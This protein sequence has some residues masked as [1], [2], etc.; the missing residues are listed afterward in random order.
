VP[1]GQHPASPRFLLSLLAT[2]VYLSV[3]AVATQALTAIMN[4]VGPHTVVRYLDFAIG[5]GVGDADGGPEPDAAVGL[6]GVARAVP[7]E[8]ASP[9]DEPVDVLAD[10]RRLEIHKEGPSDAASVSSDASE[11]AP[12]ERAFDY[13][14][15]STKIGEAAACWLARWGRDILT[16]EQSVVD[17]SPWSGEG[18][19]GPSRPRAFTLPSTPSYVASATH[20]V[21]MIWRRGGLSAKW[22]GAVL[23]SDMLF[24]RGEKER[25]EMV[26]D[27]VELRRRQGID[28]AEEKEWS[29]VFA[30][31]IYY[32]NMVRRHRRP[33]PRPY[34]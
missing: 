31:G 15:V 26:K 23:S 25:Y 10:L 29:E 2:A 24:V 28:D 16:Y 22:A 18:A 7:H 17:A 4:S 1:E 11:D 12:D 14:A 32:S 8:P 21:P 6:E 5:K 9:V 33:H 34:R 3:P 13:G 30:H 27:V 19:A 20:S